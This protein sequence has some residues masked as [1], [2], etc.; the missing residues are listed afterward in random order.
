MAMTGMLAGVAAVVCD[1]AV[2]MGKGIF[3]E[4]R[5]LPVAVLALSFAAV[6][7]FQVGVVTVILV[8]AGIGAADTLWRESA[9][10]WK[11]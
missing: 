8:C 6:R 1:V 10:R 11:R 2:T 3:R 5:I 9:E 4:K 7:F